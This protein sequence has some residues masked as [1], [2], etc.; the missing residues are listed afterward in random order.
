MRFSRRPVARRQ[1]PSAWDAYPSLRRT[2]PSAQS[3][4]P[5][6]GTITWNATAE[7]VARSAVAEDIGL[8]K[9]CLPLGPPLSPRA[10]PAFR[11]HET[12]AEYAQAKRR[13]R[14]RI[15]WRT[16]INRRAAPRPYTTGP[17]RSRPCH[18]KTSWRQCRVGQAGRR[19]SLRIGRPSHASCDRDLLPKSRH[20]RTAHTGRR[21]PRPDFELTNMTARRFSPRP[22]FISA[23]RGACS[24]LS[25]ILGDPHCRHELEALHSVFL[26]RHSRGSVPAGPDLDGS[27]R[28]CTQ[29]WAAP[30]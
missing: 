25:G 17:D 29:P 7:A 4:P 10:R 23:A 24:F 5:P 8:G 9:L 28:K 15:V 3:R 26:R 14:E 2:Q 16:T 12:S 18:W 22:S 19:Q 27:C 20:P 30:H 13:T 1:R 11:R 21:P 6:R